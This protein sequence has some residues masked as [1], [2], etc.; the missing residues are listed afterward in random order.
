VTTGTAKFDNEMSVMQVCPGV[1]NMAFLA[2]GALQGCMLCMNKNFRIFDF[3][4]CYQ[5]FLLLSK[6]L[7]MFANAIVKTFSKSNF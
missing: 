1:I 4:Y 7:A 2:V 3:L 5:L 6:L